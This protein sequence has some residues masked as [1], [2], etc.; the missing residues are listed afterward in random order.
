MT[1]VQSERIDKEVAEGL[2]LIGVL[3]D[4][5]PKIPQDIPA[6][7]PANITTIFRISNTTTDR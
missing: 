3:P 1:R 7:R 5:L 2:R 4:S 6:E